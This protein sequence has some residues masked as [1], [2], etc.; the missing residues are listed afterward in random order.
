MALDDQGPMDIEQRG[1]SRKSWRQARGAQ[2]E[3]D[4]MSSWIGLYHPV[5]KQMGVGSRDWGGGFSK[6]IKK[7]SSACLLQG[8]IERSYLCVLLFTREDSYHV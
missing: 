5:S 3:G 8:R 7:E 2:K 4:S 6:R 1:G